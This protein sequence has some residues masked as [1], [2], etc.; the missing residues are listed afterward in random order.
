[1]CTLIKRY[2]AIHHLINGNAGR[3]DE[4]MMVR[5]LLSQ[6]YLRDRDIAPLFP[7]NVKSLEMQWASVLYELSEKSCGE[8][9]VVVIDAL[10]ELS[11]NKN[12][13]FMPQYLPENVYVI[14]SMRPIRVVRSFDVEESCEL[15]PFSENDVYGY[16]R[17]YHRYV[18]PE[19][20]AGFYEI[21]GGNP[22]FLKCLLENERKGEYREGK[23]PESLVE[24][25]DRFVESLRNRDSEI[26]LYEEYESSLGSLLM[27]IGREEP[28]EVGT[29][30]F[31]MYLLSD[32]NAFFRDR[33]LRA[34][35]ELTD[36]AEFDLVR[37]IFQKYDAMAEKRE[38]IYRQLLK[39][40][41]GK[42]HHSMFWLPVDG[43][44]EEGKEILEGIDRERFAAQESE[45]LFLIGGNLGVLSG[46]FEEA[47]IWVDRSYRFAKDRNYRNDELRS[48]RKVAELSMAVS[49][50]RRVEDLKRYLKTGV[51]TLG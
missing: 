13:G 24:L 35:K 43:L 48:S 6:A 37:D 20:A 23:L 45:L 21:S 34:L 9:I 27:E 14:Y 4:R 26:A 17:R 12:L 19:R 31:Y 8:K 10:D 7:E 44:I 16:V 18:S 22:L 39:I 32:E 33:V 2:G 42:I 5:S 40:R 11:G 51:K 15:T 36:L 25:L 30:R 47:K 28:G 50:K 49:Q 1:M 46:N 29:G 3:D 41:I 38:D